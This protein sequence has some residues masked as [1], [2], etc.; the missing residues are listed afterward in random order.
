M[1]WLSYFSSLAPGFSMP[2][3]H[4]NKRRAAGPSQSGTFLRIGK[5]QACGGQA[6]VL[7]LTGSVDV[8]PNTVTSNQALQ[9]LT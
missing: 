8:N 5:N 1:M 7:T 3:L 9:R 6:W 2:Q 4:S